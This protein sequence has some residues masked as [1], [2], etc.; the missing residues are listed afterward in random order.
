M[1]NIYPWCTQLQV[2]LLLQHHIQDDITRMWSICN[3]SNISYRVCACVG[4]TNQIF[5]VPGDQS[6]PEK[7]PDRKTRL[8]ICSLDQCN[9]GWSGCFFLFSGAQKLINQMGKLNSLP[10]SNFAEETSLQL[11]FS[12]GF[13][14]FVSHLASAQWDNDRLVRWKAIDQGGTYVIAW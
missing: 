5:M 14:L 3:P 2:P 13:T 6:E 12:Y 4:L 10:S 11:F 7:H 1:K 9:Q 8:F